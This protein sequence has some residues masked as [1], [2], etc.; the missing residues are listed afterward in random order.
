MYSATVIICLIANMQ[1]CLIAEDSYGPY[2]T[3]KQCKARAEEMVSQVR[4]LPFHEPTHWRCKKSGD[5]ARYE[6]SIGN[7]SKDFSITS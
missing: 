6:F 1:A 5:S 2:P 7:K 3:F 4:K